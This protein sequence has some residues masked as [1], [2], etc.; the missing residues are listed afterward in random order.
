MPLSL[1]HIQDLARQ[2][3]QKAQDK[4]QAAV[5]RTNGFS[6]YLLPAALAG[7]GAGALMGY[8]SG[9][10]H[11]DGESP[12]DRRRRILKNA[13]LGLTL[14]GVAG[15]ALPAGL[16]TVGS[17]MEPMSGFHPVDAAANFGVRH[18]LPSTVGAGGAVLGYHHLGS[19]RA[20]AAESIAKLVDPEHMSRY[21]GGQHPFEERHLADA[22]H[23]D[24]VVNTV[25]RLAG[26]LGKGTKTPDTGARWRARELFGEAG[27]KLPA[28]QD[29]TGLREHLG[30][31]GLISK[32]VSRLMPGETPRTGAVGSWLDKAGPGIA[33]RY[34]RYI[35]PSV[36]GILA[37]GE[38]PYIGL[39]M[40]AG[41]L[42]SGVLGAKYVQDKIE[43][44]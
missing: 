22:T 18:W 7:G 9:R 4:G 24:P 19:N 38:A 20:H 14:G 43:G 33:E 15:G 16:K 41:L 39:P 11:I 3:S 12:R 30:G 28:E 42:G 27:V 6:P 44:N 34:S 8:M 2:M 40:A 31:Q 23:A 26:V 36:G 17:T 21:P 13:L 10:N 37:R 1:S 29:L 32:M 5:Q 25:N 35:R